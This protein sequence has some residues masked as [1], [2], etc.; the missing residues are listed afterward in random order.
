MSMGP[1]S[2]DYEYIQWRQSTSFINIFCDA[3]PVHLLQ[4]AAK[5]LPEVFATFQATTVPATV[6]CN[7]IHL[8][9]VLDYL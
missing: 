4:C 8:L 5:S 6:K 1:K 9:D 3:P 2:V 7:F